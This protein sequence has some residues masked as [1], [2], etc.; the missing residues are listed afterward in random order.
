VAPVESSTANV[1]TYQQPHVPTNMEVISMNENLS[2]EYPLAPITWSTSEGANTSKAVILFPDV[3]LNQPFIT[4]LSAYYANIK[5]G[6]RVTVRIVA[7]KFKYGQLIGAGFPAYNLIQPPTKYTQNRVAMSGLESMTFSASAGISKTFDWPFVNH[8]RATP[9]VAYTSGE[10]G[11]FMLTVL[12]PLRDVQGESSTAKIF[13]TVQFKEPKLFLPFTPTS[14]ENVEE[15]IFE[16]HSQHLT[17]AEMK[18][19]VGSISNALETMSDVVGLV[20]N[21]PIVGQYSGMAMRALS[22][23]SD[24]ARRLGLSKPT[25]LNM[26]QIYKANPY[27]DMNLGSGVSLIPKLATDGE[28]SISTIPNVGGFS[29]DEMDLNFLANTPM[30]ASIITLTSASTS[31][32]VSN[33]QS[34]EGVYVDQ[35]CR[36][37]TYFA[38][39]LQ[40]YVLINASLYHSIRI[41]F[42]LNTNNT[43]ADWQ[44]CYHRIVDVQGDT[45]TKVSIPYVQRMFVNFNQVTTTYSL[46]Y[47]ILSWSQPDDSVTAPIDLNVFKFAHRTNFAWWAPRDVYYT[48]DDLETFETHSLRNI[49]AHDFPMIHASCTGYEIDNLIGG[50]RVRTLRELGHKAYMY[51][52]QSA[53]QEILYLTEAQVLDTTSMV[54]GWVGI[55]MLTRFYVYWRGSVRLRFFQADQ[56]KVHGVFIKTNLNEVFVGNSLSCSTNPVLEIEV[57]HYS[58]RLF[59]NTIDYTLDNQPSWEVNNPEN[60]FKSKSM[61]DDFSAHHRQPLLGFILPLDD[62]DTPFVGSRG[63]VTFYQDVSLSKKQRGIG[64]PKTKSLKTLEEDNRS[65]GSEGEVTFVDLGKRDITKPTGKNDSPEM[66]KGLSS[67]LLSTVQPSGLYKQ[68]NPEGSQTLEEMMNHDRSLLGKAVSYYKS[69]FP[70][71]N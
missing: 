30:L 18:A 40:F 49:C 48:E 56:T 45:E 8:N 15:E 29:C 57:P 34:N 63:L 1:T 26:T 7:D 39:T 41:V 33:L 13:I 22:T 70:S 16:T 2:R 24:V 68:A 3:I 38:G 44:N 62:D 35:V 67:S 37:F 69:K 42:Y 54:T 71:E 11:V 4:N 21:V 23:S 5:S 59:H 9:T 58:T 64:L 10:M 19:R 28:N 60:L 25:T 66:L 12:N 51:Y 36:L 32:V 17:E 31:G 46:M 27:I 43:G 55:E 50:E 53:E 20:K 65:S 6:W 14:L 52:D 47:K 61:G